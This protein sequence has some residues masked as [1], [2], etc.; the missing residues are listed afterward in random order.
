MSRGRQPS[1]P[2]PAPS[3]ASRMDGRVL[4]TLLRQGDRMVVYRVRLEIVKALNLKFTDISNVFD[5][6]TGYAIYP[7]TADVRDILVRPENKQL[8]YNALHLSSVHFPEHWH[9]YVIPE[10]P[11]TWRNLTA[12][13]SV[14]STTEEMVFE[15][16]T[17][18]AGQTPKRVWPSRNINP[19]TGRGS[20]LA[21]FLEP[22]SKPFMIFG[23]SGYARMIEKKERITLHDPG[24]QGYCNGRRCMR[25]ARCHN[26]SRDL[27]THPQEP[28]N[29]PPKCANCCGPYISGH[30]D[31]PAAP[32]KEHGKIVFPTD[33]QKRQ[34]R[35]AGASAYNA[36][37]NAKGKGNEK[38]KASE[39]EAKQASDQLAHENA[40]ATA[41]TDEIV[42]A[43]DSSSGKQT[44]S[45]LTTASRSSKR[46][47][48]A[49]S[50]SRPP[51]R[52]PGSSFRPRGNAPDY[53]VTNYY[54]PLGLDGEEGSDGMEITSDQ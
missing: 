43:S 35:N 51:T 24:C 17:M 47:S 4:A 18:Q 12:E 40:A 5:T 22:V 53:N 44:A 46:P 25:M 16:V 23:S 7:A 39:S 14:T 21:A 36:V 29:A 50:P 15:E 13:G 45:T 8:L 54:G 52:A 19:H 26:C 41:E 32:R 6:P 31:C 28:C 49:V 10:V 38:S 11:A 20:W 9:K 33:A 30:I 37:N 1:A 3:S 48:T 27:A 2:P 42:V 34:I